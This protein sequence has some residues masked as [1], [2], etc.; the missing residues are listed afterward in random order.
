MNGIILLSL[1][2][3]M[4]M[5]AGIFNFRK[6]I[7]PIAI[8]AMLGAVF[9]YV[10][11][12]GQNLSFFNNMVTFDNY[13]I[14]FTAIVISTAALLL[15]FAIY[16]Y[17]FEGDYIT[18]IYALLIFATVG[19]VIMTA[20]SNLAML[21]MGI[22]ILSIPLYVLAGSRRADLASNEAALKYFLMGAF[23]TG[24]LLFGIA[25]VY[26]ATG[27]FSLDGISA[28]VANNG[29][30]LPPM[31]YV[32]VVMLLVAMLFKVSAAPFHFWAPDVYQGS[33][34]LVTAYM[35]TVVKIAA[36]AALYR[37]FDVCFASIKGY[38]EILL[39]VATILTLLVGN[40]TALYQQSFKRMMAYSGISHAGY[41][42]LA[43]LAM[44]A[45]SAG[46][47]FYYSAA[48]AVASLIAFGV[49]MA[50][51]EGREGRES[52][53]AFKGLGKTNPFLAFC[54]TAAMLSLAGIPPL[55]G[56]F[57]KYYLFTV[58]IQ[59]GYM[60]MVFI[61]VLSSLISLYYYFKVI[62]AMYSTNADMEPLKPHPVLIVAM[63]IC[64]T[65]SLVF[66]FAPDLL[67]QLL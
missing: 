4:A 13:A 35:S 20:Y 39:I 5:F 37:L 19:G 40:L 2:G 44:G 12:W 46:V 27:S 64:L 22:E 8:V 62:L 21:F 47:I 25:L 14:A 52:F 9:T 56:F 42:L 55:A 33:P 26:G 29:A 49:L 30:N 54:L 23:A 45:Q 11:T 38:Y 43:V 3:V 50:V 48:Y 10:T 36:F 32:G 15:L 61:A 17:R 41:M 65:L 16:H 66:G 7:L 18:D 31:F 63:V 53:D 51:G 57:G 28:Y 24:V 58:A 34:V 1:L 60:W 6:L 59:N 67:M